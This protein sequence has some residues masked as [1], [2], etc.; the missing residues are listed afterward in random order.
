[1]GARID[2]FKVVLKILRV[3][4]HHPSPD[5]PKSLF[6]HQRADLLL[7][8]LLGFRC[9]CASGRSRSV[10]ASVLTSF[11]RHLTGVSVAGAKAT[12]HLGDQRPL[13]EGFT[14]WCG[15]GKFE[16]QRQSEV[17]A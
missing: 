12:L 14:R 4:Q 8:T 2:R 16:W 5:V 6:Y 15:L 9:G 17:C 1:M 3:H 10:A 11:P 7:S 13:E